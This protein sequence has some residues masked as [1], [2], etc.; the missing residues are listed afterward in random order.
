MATTLGLAI[1]MAGT[2]AGL[3]HPLIFYV[4]MTAVGLGNG[5]VLPNAN[6]LE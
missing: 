3:H 4:M 5:M 6:A 2:L 1:L